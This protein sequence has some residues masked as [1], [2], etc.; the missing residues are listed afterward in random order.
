VTSQPL[1]SLASAGR[2]NYLP[3]S[4]ATVPESQSPET[5]SSAKALVTEPHPTKSKR[6]EAA[7]YSTADD[8]GA[9]L[10]S[11][12]NKSGLERSTQPYLA[13]RG[14]QDR[15]A[16]ISFL[17]CVLLPVAFAAVYY[18]FMASNQFVA[19]FRFTVKDAAPRTQVAN[20]PLMSII[21]GINGTNNAD[22]Y[23][24]VDYLTSRQ[25]VEEL[26]KRIGVTKLYSKPMIDWWSRYNPNQPIEK[27]ISYW[28]AAVTAR[29]DQVTGI[30]F[31]QVKAYTPEDALL[32]ATSLVALSEELVN[33]IASRTQNDAV[34]FAEREV[35]KSEKRLLETRAKLTEYRNRTGVI[36]PTASVA[37]SNAALVQ[38]LRATL[39][40]LET[41]QSALLRQQLDPTSPTLSVLNNQIRSTKEQLQ[42]VES[43]I[44]QDRD[45]VSLSRVVAEYEQLD[46]ER[47]FAQTMVT[48][49]MQAL[50]QARA[51]AASQHLY[52]TPYV[53]PHLPQ[54]ATYPRRFF[55]V[56]VVAGIAF[57]IWIIAL[58][59][60]RSIRERFS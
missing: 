14:G 39:A 48:S 1:F 59:V 21:G 24:V 32:I 27:F 57:L 26:E 4:G 12:R 38:S 18:G 33:S 50:D 46:L 5:D 47:Q 17:I 56:L 8:L 2:R 55:S 3:S 34:R 9:R 16:L 29:Y 35:Q 31:A 41:Q 53:Q 6:L 60:G 45:G 43:S 22:N 54:S 19:E 51:S 42:K 23:L 36:D 7:A 30:A 25:A 49:A 15:T 40:Q 20:N 44:L 52:I 13:S 37:A 58:L 11:E 10:P 28:Q